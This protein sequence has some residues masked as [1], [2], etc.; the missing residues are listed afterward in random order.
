[1]GEAQRQAQELRLEQA[2]EAVVVLGEPEEMVSPVEHE[3]RIYVHDL[4]TANHEKDFRSLA[5]FPLQALQEAKVVVL[6]ADY[7]GGLMVE[8]VTGGQ[9]A[10]GGWILP[11]L[12]WKGHMGG[13][14]PRRLR[15]GA[16][17]Q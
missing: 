2:V 6:R 14:T 3:A 4:L 9:W 1:M 13:R 15:P 8:S 10:R 7:R 17:R 11:V 5:M 16:V 12:I